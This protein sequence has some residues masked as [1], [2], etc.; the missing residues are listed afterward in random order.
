M[1]VIKRFKCDVCGYVHEGSEPPDT[2]PV[3]GVGRDLFSEVATPTA[4]IVPAPPTPA[5]DTT[6]PAKARRFR[7]SVCGE[8]V[9]GDAPPA[10]CPT[11]FVDANL[12]VVDEP[13][14]VIAP[15]ER[16]RERIVIV[17]AGVA[18]LTAA[19]H[20]RRAANAEIVLINK[21]P[22]AP[23]HRLNLTRL[24]AGE[25][26]EGSLPL[27]PRTWFDE[28]RIQLLNEDV[29][30]V[31]RD[32]HE[33]VMSGQRLRYDRLVLANGAHA[34]VP[35]IP[36]VT[37]LAVFTVRTLDDT[38]SLAAAA[39]PGRR[40]VIIGGGL[41]GLEVAAALNGRGVSVTVL[42]GFDWL[43][44]RQ[45]ARPVAEH[46]QARLAAIGVTVR[47]GAKVAKLA[48]DETIRGVRLADE[49][50]F[51]AELVVIAAG[52]RP[53]SH[54]A[55]Q[56]GLAVGR[57]IL[58]DDGMRTSDPDV[59]AAGDVTEHRGVV[60]GLWAPALAEG[61][62]AGANAAGSC[63]DYVPSPPSN[64]LKVLEIPVFGVGQVAATDGA[65][66]VREHRDERVHRYF[67]LRDGKL[68]GAN[69]L[70]EMALA[71]AVTIAVETGAQLAELTEP[72][73]GLAEL[74]GGG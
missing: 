54:L 44:P 39:Q 7:C 29:V 34:F 28:Q 14:P 30:A 2:C 73:A 42:E 45:L 47:C 50:E 63:R 35:P 9:V 37:R 1:A 62:V 53:N 56:A 4:A 3:C 68:V 38:R 59:F 64:Q 19:E 25:I 5:A 13:P 18:G 21:E 58:V 27:R 51:P 65:F 70:G 10:I 72:L 74:R 15:T 61:A 32:T 24:L 60:S 67:L 40:C 41:L 20:A 22:D 12:F 43:L 71:G 33:L 49:T 46:L 11:C 48:G 31:D 66:T 57:G 6:A 8:I 17:G 16:H 55:R 26:A 69:L 23:Y 36:G 52:V